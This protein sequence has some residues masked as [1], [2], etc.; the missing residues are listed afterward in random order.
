MCQ[1]TKTLPDLVEFAKEQIYL[2]GQ[3]RHTMY[4]RVKQH[5]P[6]EA[7]PSPLRCVAGRGPFANRGT[8]R[9]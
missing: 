9:A 2:R 3:D 6:A 7:E 1:F 8:Q 4:I 5:W